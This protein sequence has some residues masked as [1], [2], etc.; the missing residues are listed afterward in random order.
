MEWIKAF[1]IPLVLMVC[2]AVFVGF[3][4]STTAVFENTVTNE[5]FANKTSKVGISNYTTAY[6]GTD[7]DTPIIYNGTQ[8]CAVCTATFTPG[9][10]LRIVLPD[11]TQGVPQ[12]TYVGL[13]DSHYGTWTNI[14]EGGQ[15]GFDLAAMLPYAIIGLTILALMLKAFGVF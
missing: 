2:L 10:G 6:V 11:G 7:D 14:S 5:T 15:N 13:S 12:V 9:L 3:S 1:I 8:V 4:G